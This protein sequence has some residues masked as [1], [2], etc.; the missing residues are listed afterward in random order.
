MAPTVSVLLAVYNARRYLRQAIDSILAQTFTDF[1]FIIIDDGSTDDTLAILRE[2]EKRDGR[3]RLISRP[4]KG[5][6]TT[7]NEGLALA[8]GEF[9]ARMDGDDVA[10]PTRFEKQVTYL[11]DHPEC[12]LVG[13]RVL[14]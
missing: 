12:V 14:L 9:L 10:L 5:L 4:N 1:E 11:R 6:T 13:S 8:R 2:Y 7:L 3:I